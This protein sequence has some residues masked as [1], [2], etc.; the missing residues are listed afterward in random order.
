VTVSICLFTLIFFV[1]FLHSNVVW[2]PSIIYY[3]LLF[4]FKLLLWTG[5]CTTCSLIVSFSWIVTKL[6]LHINRL[7]ECMQSIVLLVCS[8]CCFLWIESSLIISRKTLKRYLKCPFH[9]LHNRQCKTYPYLRN[10]F[11]TYH[12]QRCGNVHIWHT[13]FTIINSW[14]VYSDQIFLQSQ[15]APRRKCC[16]NYKADHVNI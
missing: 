12:K 9:V 1:E 4:H 7:G 13:S 15:L 8:L 14:L 16:L 3:N 11:T 2:H 10:R 5:V 6:L